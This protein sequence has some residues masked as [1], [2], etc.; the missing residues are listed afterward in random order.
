[1]ERIRLMH[2]PYGEVEGAWKTLEEA[3]ETGN[4]GIGQGERDPRPGSS[5]RGR[6]APE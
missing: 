1:M 5:R 3:K 6:N 2:Q 4:Q